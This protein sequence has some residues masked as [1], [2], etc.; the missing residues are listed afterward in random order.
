ML[1]RFAIAVLLAG[2]LPAASYS[3][4][5][6]EV[7]LGSG[8]DHFALMACGVD[9]RAYFSRSFTDPDPSSFGVGLSS[10]LGVSRDGSIVTFQPPDKATPVVAAVDSSGLSVLAAH[11]RHLHEDFRWEIYQLDNQANLL[12]HHSAAIGFQP[13]QMAVLPSGRMTIA[14][15]TGDLSWSHRDQWN[16]VGGIFDADGSMIEHFKFPSPTDGGK[17]T[18]NSREKM[19]ERNGAA[20]VVLQSDSSDA[21]AIAR[22]SES[23]SVNIKALPESPDDDQRHHHLWLLGPGIAVEE[24]SY[25][26]ERPRIRMHYDEYDLNSGKKIATKVSAGGSATCYYGTEVNWIAPDTRRLFFNRLENQALSP[27][28]SGH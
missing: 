15:H 24:Y 25:T 20:Y 6:G 11:P 13:V 26:G 14:G 7:L 23:G 19:I 27:P 1:S 28:P 10:V 2:I 8:T 4:E 22:I 18:F 3:Q 9:G 16:Y 5:A 17:W 21:A 12:G